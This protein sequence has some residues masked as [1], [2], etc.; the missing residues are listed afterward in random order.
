MKGIHPIWR[1]NTKN[2]K[3][4]TLLKSHSPDLSW[5]TGCISVFIGS[6]DTA[7]RP[8]QIAVKEGGNKNNETTANYRT[9]PLISIL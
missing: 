9:F 3:Q 1:P 8:E 6:P 4:I 2:T 5:S 7:I